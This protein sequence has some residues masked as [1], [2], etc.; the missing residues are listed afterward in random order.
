MKRH[1]VVVGGATVLALAVLVAVMFVGIPRSWATACWGCYH[2]NAPNGPN[3]PLRAAIVAAPEMMVD[4]Q[5]LPGKTVGPVVKMN[6][7]TIE[8]FQFPLPPRWPGLTDR[9]WV[10]RR[11]N[12]ALNCAIKLNALPPNR[13]FYWKE[14]PKNHSQFCGGHDEECFFCSDCTD[15]RTCGELP[16]LRPWSV[17]PAG[18]R[19]PRQTK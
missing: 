6:A 16:G 7:E 18:R 8:P 1:D 11:A 3:S 12:Y 2:P 9:E 15:R 10:I 17:A 14:E 5:K 19:K 13:D 4:G